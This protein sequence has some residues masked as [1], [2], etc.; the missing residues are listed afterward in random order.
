VR[1]LRAQFGQRCILAGFKGDQGPVMLGTAQILFARLL[2]N[3][4]GDAA[5]LGETLRQCGSRF[6]QHLARPLDLERGI[7]A[8]T[9]QRLLERVDGRPMV[10]GDA[11]ALDR[12][13]FNERVE[14]PVFGG[15]GLK[16]PLEDLQFVPLAGL[17]AGESP[18]MLGD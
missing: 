12:V 1:Q 10:G 18:L 2:L 11:L 13:F 15:R 5:L 6:G 16:A 7:L 14:A 8:R 9:S 17:D 4:G 3:A